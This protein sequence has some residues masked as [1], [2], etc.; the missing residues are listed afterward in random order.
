MLYRH[1]KVL[2][3]H[4]LKIKNDYEI[5]V[6][7]FGLNSHERQHH[8]GGV[9]TE[10]KLTLTSILPDRDTLMKSTK[11]KSHLIKLLSMCSFGSNVKLTGEHDSAMR[12]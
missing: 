10:H 11:N 1:V 4:S 3:R 9:T 5:L 6:V 7:P 8:A 12:K 2:S